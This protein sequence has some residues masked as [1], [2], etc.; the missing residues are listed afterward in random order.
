[1][2]QIAPP[3]NFELVPETAPFSDEQRSWLNGFFA[4]LVSLDNGVTPLSAEQGA[5][6]M[7]SSDADDG[8]APWHDQ[9]IPINEPP[10]PI[11]FPWG[12]LVKPSLLFFQAAFKP[13]HIYVLL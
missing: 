3:P 7:T 11:I 2:N 8:E 5:A 10:P 12:K 4:G 1:M 9:T 6:F 13:P